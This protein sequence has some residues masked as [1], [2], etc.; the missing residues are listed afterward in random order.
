[1]VLALL[2]IAHPVSAE[3][4]SQPPALQE[5]I[6]S[7]GEAVRALFAR[8]GL[9]YP[10][11]GV[12][13]RVF[14]RDRELE[15]WGERRNGE[16][17]LV[18]T[19]RICASSGELG[20]K[21]AEGDGQVPEGFYSIAIYNPRSTFHL[22]LGIDY[23]NRS[24]RIRSGARR[25]GGAI[26]IHGNCVT[27]GCVP[28]TDPLIDEVFL[29]AWEAHTHGQQRVEAHFF[30]S[31]LDAAGWEELVRE[32]DWDAT[33]LSF[34]RELRAGYDAFDKTHR[35]PLVRVEA[36]GRYRVIEQHVGG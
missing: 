23:P 33:R 12:F 31:R 35:P 34:W 9:D 36:D 10:P 18:K 19:Y 26:M 30:P 15:L 21:R 7:K 5:A 28:I 16:Y 25:L 27:I 2:S 3:P 20:P 6:S 8:Q 11:R 32:R 14:K 22:A 24:D 4:M 29:A 1:L 13:I 17:A